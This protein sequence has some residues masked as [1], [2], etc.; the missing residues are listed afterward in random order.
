MSTY[1]RINFAVG[2]DGGTP[3]DETNLNKMEDAVASAHA[4]LDTCFPTGM[5]AYYPKS[6]I[7]SGWLECNGQTASRTTYSVLFN[8]IGTT[9]GAG[10]GNTTFTLPDYRG[11][12][13]RGL[14]TRTTTARDKCYA[15]T[16]AARALG[17]TQADSNIAHSHTFTRTTTGN[18]GQSGSS[19]A[20]QWPTAT[21]GTTHGNPAGEGRPK[22]MALM[23]MIKT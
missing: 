3:V 6:T 14:D 21:A 23:V 22:N 20:Y 18:G 9:Y 15:E 1:T 11:Y 12:F 19:G 2:P 17:S 5:I 7:P 4:E 16:S 8:T 10:D 13:L